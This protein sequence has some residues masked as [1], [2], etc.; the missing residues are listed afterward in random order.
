MET[1]TK[2]V[3][4]LTD[5]KLMQNIKEGNLS[6]MSMLFERYNRRLYNFFLKMGLKSDM[7]QDLTQ[8]L[9]YRMIKYRHTYKNNA[10][11]KT[12][13]Y[14]IARNL[15]NDF[16]SEEKRSGDMFMTS[17]VYPSDLPE[18]QDNYA[19]EDFER[20]DK[21]LLTLSDAQR[22]I[23]ILSRYQGLKYEEISSVVKQTVPAIKVTV[24]RAIKQLRSVYF[25]Q[26]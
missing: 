17:G 15:H 21:A 24:Y 1:I 2:T 20:L 10:C 6:G 8:N 19:E 18:E 11:V 26:T 16:R 14:Q 13:I 23:I 4:N 3:Q 9:F 22:E 7:S 12:W 5:E 25:K